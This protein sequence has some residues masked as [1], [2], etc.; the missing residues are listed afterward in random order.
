MERNSLKKA[1][2]DQKEE[3]SLLPQR[4]KL[5]ERDCF[6]Q[7][8][9]YMESGQVK[10]IIGVRR[11]G[12]S[13]LSYQLLSGRQFAYINFDDEKLTNLKADELNDVLE[14][15]YE[16][17]G[18]IKYILLD[19]I[20]NIEGWE[21]FVN[22]LQ[23]QGFNVIVTGSNANLLSKELS[24]HLTGRN[25]PLELFPFSFMEFL[26]TRGVEVKKV[27]AL[28]TKERAE[29]KFRL[30]EY[31]RIGGF[32]EVVKEPINKKI[33]LQSLYSDIINKDII[34]R[35]R[36]KF[37]KTLRDIA[38]YLISNTSSMVGS[39]KISNIFKLKSAHTASNYLAFFEE[40]M[41]F[42]TLSRF[43][44]KS[45]ERETAQRKIY[46]ID[47]GMID[48]VGASFSPNTG[49]IYENVVFLELMRR[50]QR[51]R[52]ELFYWQDVYKGE[53]DFIVKEGRKIE[54]AIQVCF[55]VGNYDT[56]KREIESLAKVAKELKCDNLKVIT[57]D[58]ESE[59]NTEGFKIDFIPLWKWL[60]E[61]QKI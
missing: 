58:F 9:S 40:S 5:I 28:S 29:L 6:K 13:I 56:K 61:E 43:S 17:Y 2:I 20:Q 18:N 4:K 45:K 35:H 12:K 11:C 42:F 41:L 54:G 57:G 32:P 24:T 50:K 53:V 3:I 30:E 36:I 15:I 14:V 59:E 34:I 48:A 39:N 38:N 44:F 49:R 16:I 7:Y 55:D 21:L 46:A 31:L 10:V 22:R 23:R 60:L 8:S 27:D 37:S 33:Y 19:E 47:T 26:K 25:I 52:F 1:L 51:N